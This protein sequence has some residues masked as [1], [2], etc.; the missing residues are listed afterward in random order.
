MNPGTFT[1]DPQNLF[2]VVP[3]FSQEKTVL[4][5]LARLSCPPWP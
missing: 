4:Q 3:G 1:T 5:T 2:V